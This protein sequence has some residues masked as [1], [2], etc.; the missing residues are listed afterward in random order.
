MD[1]P[2]EEAVFGRWLRR[3]RK[4]LDLT[5]KALARKV[6]CSPA[7]IRKLEADERHPSRHVA[8]ALAKALAVPSEEHAA[9]VRF[10]RA[11]W[12]GDGAPNALPDLERPWGV[13]GLHPE[14]SPAPGTAP[15]FTEAARSAAVGNA[16][17]ADRGEQ[18]GPAEPGGVVAHGGHGQQPLPVVARDA[19]L[20]RLSQAL[21]RA[22][23]GRGGVVLV[24]GEAGQGKTT[25]LKTFAARAQAT[26]RDLLVATGACNAY[27]G[28][29][30]PFLP[31]REVLQQLTGDVSATEQLDAFERGRADRL[32]R[33]LPQVVEIVQEFGPGLVGA[34][35]APEGL[36]R[37]LGRAGLAVPPPWAAPSPAR[38]GGLSEPPGAS[39]R[40]ALRAATVRVLHALAEQA[41]LL[42]LLDDL[43]W[44]DRSSVDVLLQLA[45]T[46]AERRVLVLGAYRPGDLA[47]G[48]DGAPHGMVRVLHAVERAYGDAVIDL[49]RGDGRAFLEAWLDTQPNRL[50]AEFREALWRQT[51]GHPLFTIELL[52]AMQ[53]RGD[54]ARDDRG[55]WAATPALAWDALP[56]RVS[57]A[58]AE[59][60]DRL[61][62][63]ART[64][65]KVASV[66]GESFTAEVTAHV[67]GRDPR[68]VVATL[69][70]RLAREQLLVSAIEVR[71]NAAGLISR[72]R[73]RHE[74]IQRFVYDTVDEGERSYL[75]EAVA[76]ALEA[77]L[78]DEADPLALARHYTRARLPER[79]AVHYRDAG[80][81]ARNAGALDQAVDAYRAAI[82][83]WADPNPASRAPLLRDLGECQWLR[84]AHLEGRAALEEA[85]AIYDAEGDVRS[86]ALARLFL[87]RTFYDDGDWNRA[88]EIRRR[89]VADLERGPETPEL[90]LAQ[91]G[92]AAT[93]QVAHRVT[94]AV[95]WAQRALD[96]ADRVHAEG[97]R[98]Q[99]LGRLGLDFAHQP[100]RRDEGL[101]MLDDSHAEAH[102]LGLWRLAST[103]LYNLGYTCGALGRKAEAEQRFEA[104]LSYAR[105]Y[106]LARDEA[107]ARYRLWQLRWRAGRWAEALAER[108]E[109]VRLTDGSGILDTPLHQ[110]VTLLA[111][112][113]VDLGQGTRARALLEAHAPR[114]ERVS[115][116]QYRWPYLRVRLRAA[117]LEGRTE[118]ADAV[119][120]TV[121]DMSHDATGID[122]LVLPALSALRWLA[123]RSS[124]ELR[125]AGRPCLDVIA[126]A[127]ARYA[128]PETGAALAEGHGALASGSDDDATAARHLTDAARHWHEGGLPFDEARARGAAAHVLS[129]CGGLAEAA[130]EREEAEAILEGLAEQ[131]P[132]AQLRRSFSRVQRAILAP[133]DTPLP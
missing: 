77:V 34:L 21:D 65:L 24:A 110:A 49:D 74:L 40:A 114:L 53:D 81:R 55:D 23:A 126:H 46:V 96:T 127:H 97:A 124:K 31:F 100:D 3:R 37:R 22:L 41:P 66:E 32:R 44:V 102:R 86:A 90:A 84:G 39:G 58:L 93:Y 116:P 35:L 94:E 28:T 76:A 82:E 99:A 112:A 5:Q 113:D 70:G 133:G 122:T 4:A 79:A 88:L 29:G 108:A 132:S 80:D 9:F 67:L 12:A 115:E 78:R 56:R 119:A 18:Q 33:L 20:G 50:D 51:G 107:M 123:A 62:A 69:G 26:E 57:G 125:D 61:D 64:I 54:I 118:D 45:N 59:R 6:G 130:T 117:A 10:A 7:T 106:S 101:R 14:S 30:D 52:R 95:A 43:Q 8:V 38:A 15:G 92:L 36:R 120:L 83:H 105:R 85:L 19:E 128:S 27:T 98:A 2:Q 72:Y 121:A 68:T 25:L 71:R 13:G 42:L 11:G 89:A 48:D 109:I 73:F 91:S 87:G 17:A 103:S 104:A 63:G 75:H 16:D 47:S 129:R 1:S 111:A 131:L 60:I